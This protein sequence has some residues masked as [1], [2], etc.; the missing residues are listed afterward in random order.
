MGF[1]FTINYT[2]NI[3]LNMMNSKLQNPSENQKR[4]RNG[5]KSFNFCLKLAKLKYQ[6][7]S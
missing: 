2:K 6:I 7:K 4:E 3:S 1:F 5:K